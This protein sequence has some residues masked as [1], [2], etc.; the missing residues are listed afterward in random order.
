[1]LRE[2]CATLIRVCVCGPQHPQVRRPVCQQTL[3]ARE[4]SGKWRMSES[5][6]RHSKLM[7]DKSSLFLISLAKMAN[8]SFQACN[9]DGLRQ[10]WVE[11][12]KW[13]TTGLA[14]YFND[15]APRESMT[16]L[17]DGCLRV[18][19]NTGISGCDHYLACQD[20]AD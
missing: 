18:R 14:S 5:T 16:L 9:V 2:A 6:P 8:P 17:A 7:E 15:H 10:I 13:Q 20:W 1:M 11:C 3:L 19:T 12:P 4:P